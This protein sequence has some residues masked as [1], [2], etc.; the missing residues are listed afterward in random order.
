MAGTSASE[1]TWD[2]TPRL[3]RPLVVL[4]FRGLFD[5][6]NAA[7]AAAEWLTQRDGSWQVIPLQLPG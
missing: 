6:G 7:T 4:A 1:L 3:R 2:A 5:A